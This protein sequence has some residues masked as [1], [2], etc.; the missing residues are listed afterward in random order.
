MRRLVLA[1]GFSMLAACQCGSLGV[2]TTRFACATDA[3]CA[4]GFVCR[5]E[6]SGKECVRPGSD[7]GSGG[8]TGGGA[9]GGG[10]GGGG[11]VGGGTGGGA[12]G[13]GTGG[14]GDDGGVGG[15]AGGGGDDGG[16]GGGGGTDAGVGGGT[17]GG[18]AA[19][20][21]AL[22]FVTSPQTVASGTC[23]QAVTVETRDAMDQPAPVAA[24]T[25]VDFAAAP[26]GLTF[27]RNQNCNG[28]PATSVTINGGTTRGTI[29]F[30]GAMT[31]PYTVTASATG[32]TPATQVAVIGQAPNGLVFTSTP[33]ATTRGGSC[34]AASVEATRGGSAASVVTN[35]PVALTATPTGATRFYA[36]ATCSTSTTTATIVAGTATASFFVQ[37][38]TAGMSTITATASF[39]SDSQTF[40]A[41]PIVRRGNCAFAAPSMLADGGT[42][43][44]NSRTCSFSP[45]V[46]NVSQAL[47]FT[48][49]IATATT[50]GAL[51][52]RCRLS[53]TTTV[54]C[55]RGNGDSD[56]P[57]HYQVAE[58]PQGLTVQRLSSSGCPASL[59]LATPV[60][61]AHSFLVKTMST[62]GTVFDDED[63][64]AYVLDPAGGAA[65]LV[66]AACNGI[67]LQVVE[68]SGVTVTHAE[69]DGGLPAGLDSARLALSPASNA[70]VL[71]VQPR[72][73]STVEQSVC[74]LAVR[75][76]ITTP[77]E[78][79]LQRGAGIADGGCVGRLVDNVFVDRVDLGAHAA[80]QQK[81]VTLMA[82]DLSGA[83]TI[84][85]VDTSR[86]VVFAGTM[87]GGGQAV[88][89]TDDIATSYINEASAQFQL[90][91]SD[92]VTVT[93]AA[94]TSTAVF[95]FYVV[96]LVP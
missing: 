68:W 35:T 43:T 1:F 55:N 2:D 21:V 92:T 67:D 49:V 3:D 57:I 72:T 69:L 22:V 94:A 42:S 4:D 95:T 76:S 24:T 61:P 51:Q 36:D 12:V 88:G 46:Q 53:S 87:L 56:A 20:P 27:F 64:S 62:T 52:A 91:A 85:P 66:G 17:G 38:L 50:P 14:G 93:R 19:P 96:E 34:L 79:T 77:S 13:G 73:S 63:T 5:D 71:L 74:D 86:T 30:Q 16:V 39:G 7:G 29:F 59:S 75:G 84:S 26:T 90:T 83:V 25:T 58:I 80:V 65:T 37:P 45:A 82:G 10:T 78:V 54:A 32:L 6:G 41:L 48:Q 9:M 23:S 33:P 40:D 47:L 81:M 31:G 15:G 70:S 60:D 28:Q 11:A 8:G 44:S 89:E 18:T